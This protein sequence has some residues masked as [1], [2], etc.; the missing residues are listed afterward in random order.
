M[1][2][3]DFDV[4]AYVRALQRAWHDADVEPLLP[5]LADD[6]EFSDVTTIV[7]GRG[8]AG[9]RA[10]A[11]SWL[12]RFAE[13]TMEPVATLHTGTQAAVL[14]SI[15]ARD[16]G[17]LVLEDGRRLPPTGRRLEFAVAEFLTLDEHGR[18]AHDNMVADVAGML[19]ALDWT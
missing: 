13:A 19:R 14:G 2:A 7:P 11:G 12:A 5:H 15:R 3:A 4:Q 18:I 10:W 17:G 16:V 6:V 9:W 8:K 1:P